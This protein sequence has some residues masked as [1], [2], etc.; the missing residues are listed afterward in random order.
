MVLTE[1]LTRSQLPNNPRPNLAS[2]LVYFLIITLFL[3]YESLESLT[4]TA[5]SRAT[6]SSSPGRPYV[7]GPLVEFLLQSQRWSLQ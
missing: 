2:S 4:S 1:V 3:A 7:P 5:R 6:G